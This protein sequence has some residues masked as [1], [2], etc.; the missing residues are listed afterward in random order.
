MGLSD[1]NVRTD[2]KNPKEKGSHMITRKSVA[3]RPRIVQESDAQVLLE[4]DT[5]QRHALMERAVK[6]WSN[7]PGSSIRGFSKHK[8]VNFLE[9][10]KD[11]ER[12]GVI[13]L[14]MENTYQWLTGT[15]PVNIDEMTRTTQIGSLN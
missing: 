12:A 1:N 2:Y 9:G 11:P 3:E 13:A 14:L 4:N 10:I 6:R 15:G 8:H 5:S 7:M